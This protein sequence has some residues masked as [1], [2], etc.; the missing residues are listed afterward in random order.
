MTLRRP[1]APEITANFLPPLM[2]RRLILSLAASLTLH[3]AVF[4]GG[5]L[6]ALLKP[7]PVRVLQASLRLPPVE[8]PPAES[9]LKDTLAPEEAKPEPKVE[10]K[11]APTPRPT[12]APRPAKAEK[13]E[14]QAAQRKIARHT[15]YPPEAIAR[16]IEG[17]VRLLLVLGEDGAISDV[18]I[19]ASSGHAILDNAAIKAAYAMGRLTG[20]TAREMI[21][22]VSFRLQ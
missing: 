10:P 11:P 12:P 17:D 6:K 1:L 18:Q 4:G 9:L 15:Y 22:P 7:P 21:L 2:H 16:N 20:V 13:R 8:L 5:A 3:A 19:A 14:V